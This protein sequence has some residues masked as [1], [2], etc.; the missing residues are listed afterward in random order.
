MLR[1]EVLG[2]PTPARHATPAGDT[3]GAE[4]LDLVRGADTFFLG[5]THPTRGNDASHR[6]GPPGFVRVEDER[7]LWWP[8]Y[9]GNTM[10][11]SLGNL[12]VDPAASL[13]FLDFATG[14]SLHLSGRAALDLVDAGSPGDDAGTGRVV[15]FRVDAVTE[16][17]PLP[18]RAAHVAAYSRNPPLHP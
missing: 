13:L 18:L 14:R 3:L 5:T 7:T 1:S 8:D 2:A 12:A 10:F 6:G 9:P 4:Q 16:G 11:N 17:S 15:R